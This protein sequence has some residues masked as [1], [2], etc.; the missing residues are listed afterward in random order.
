[1]SARDVQ[2]AQWHKNKQ[3][4]RARKSISVAGCGRGSVKDELGTW[5]FIRTV[6]YTQNL[7]STIL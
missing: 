2:R 4:R 7:G 1:M 6:W 3:S 5:I